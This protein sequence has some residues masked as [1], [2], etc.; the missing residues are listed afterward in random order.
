MN[1]EHLLDF[2]LEQGS[3]GLIY[4]QQGIPI[5]VKWP[6]LPY[7]CAGEFKKAALPSCKSTYL[8]KTITLCV[9]PHRHGKWYQTGSAVGLYGRREWDITFALSVLLH[10]IVKDSDHR[11]NLDLILQEDLYV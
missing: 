10:S 3:T 11:F 9:M 8:P 4:V 6:G 7:I 5:P 2:R 1:K